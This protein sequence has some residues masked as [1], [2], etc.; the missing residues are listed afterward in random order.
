MRRE[1]VG[2][3]FFFGGTLGEGGGLSGLFVLVIL[4]FFYLP[5][6]VW[7]RGWLDMIVL[8]L[9]RCVCGGLVEGPSIRFCFNGCWV[10]QNLCLSQAD[11]VQEDWRK[12]KQS[13]S[14]KLLGCEARSMAGSRRLIG[15]Y[16][17]IEST[18][19]HGRSRPARSRTFLPAAE[20]RVEIG[21]TRRRQNPRS[22]FAK[23]A[24]TLRP[25]SP[26]NHTTHTHTHDIS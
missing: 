15:S 7:R 8:S 10:A 20:S 19:P 18:P 12:K 13:Q 24:D 16:L 14:C 21:K 22:T 26:N 1:E 17:P 11:V 6:A 2:G 4:L 5:G 23:Q 25:K 9:V 3:C